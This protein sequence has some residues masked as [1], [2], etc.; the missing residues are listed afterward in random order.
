MPFSLTK[1]VFKEQKVGGSILLPLA[2]D[3][4]SMIG[5]GCCVWKKNTHTGSQPGDKLSHDCSFCWVRAN[6]LVV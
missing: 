5:L 3:S 4:P 1:L 6:S 2:T